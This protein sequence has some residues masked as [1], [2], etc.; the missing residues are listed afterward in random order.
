MSLHALSRAVGHGSCRR[1][2]LC[3]S[4]DAAFGR[5]RRGWGYPL[6]LSRLEVRLGWQVH[7]TA[8]RTRQI[9]RGHPHWFLSDR[10]VPGPDL[11]LF[12]RG[13][14]RRLRP[15]IRRSRERGL[16][17]EEPMPPN[18][19]SIIS[20]AGRTTGTPITPALRT[21]MTGA[22]HDFDYEA[23]LVSEKYEARLRLHPHDGYRRRPYQPLDPDDAG[24]DPA[25]D[26]DLQRPGRR[27]RWADGAGDLYRSC[28]DR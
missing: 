13:R 7:R 1:S 17:I 21:H 15:T 23:T 6:P 2:P 28:T 3:P 27:R 11:C 19:R 18:S 9:R 5:L 20:K 8:G 12:R 14:A 16:H 10:G 25:P 22:L 24:D 26:P 4:R